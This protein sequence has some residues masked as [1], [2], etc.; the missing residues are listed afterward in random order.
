MILGYIMCFLGLNAIVC[1]KG[2]LF[3]ESCRHNKIVCMSI[4]HCSFWNEVFLFQQGQH[5]PVE[6]PEEVTAAFEIYNKAFQ[7]LKGN[8]K[9]EWN[10]GL[11]QITLDLELVHKE[12]FINF[13]GALSNKN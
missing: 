1:L 3:I 7:T 2:I 10:S 9:L 11:G 6:L 4:K 13:K 8:R 12:I 5:E